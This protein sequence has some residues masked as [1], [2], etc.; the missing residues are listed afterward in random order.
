VAPIRGFQDVNREQVACHVV[1]R[2]TKPNQEKNLRPAF[3]NG[4]VVSLP[5]PGLA[6]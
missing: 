2:E 3:T 6:Y 5:C 4:H 1:S